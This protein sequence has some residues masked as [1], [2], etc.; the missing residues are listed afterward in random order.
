MA[1][2]V[3]GR[4]GILGAALLCA[5][6]AHPAPR[7]D[8]STPDVKSSGGVTI[9]TSAILQKQSRSLLDLIKAR[10]PSVEVIDNTPCPDVFLRGR[11]TITTSSNPAIYVDGQRANN[12]C[13]LDMMNVL[14]LQRVE[15]YP[16]G[17]PRGGYQSSPYGVI[18]IFIRTSD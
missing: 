12:T 10:V 15:I 7:T 6:S 2:S 4:A 8:V 16:N 5:C 11:S 17:Q 13:V 14:D 9:L 1:G 18:L 3:L